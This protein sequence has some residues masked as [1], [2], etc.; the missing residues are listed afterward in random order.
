[1]FKYKTSYFSYSQCNATSHYCWHS[2][3]HYIF[4]QSNYYCLCTCCSKRFLNKSDIVSRPVI[5]NN[6]ICDC[7]NSNNHNEHIHVSVYSFIIPW[8]II[9]YTAVISYVVPYATFTGNRLIHCIIVSL[10]NE[11]TQPVCIY[12]CYLV[13]YYISLR[14]CDY[15]AWQTVSA[16][17]YIS[18]TIN[19]PAKCICRIIN[20][21]NIP[22]IHPLS[23]LYQ[24]IPVSSHFIVHLRH[25]S[26]FHCNASHFY[27][28]IWHCTNHNLISCRNSFYCVVGI[29]RKRFY[30]SDSYCCHCLFKIWVILNHII[31]TL[32][33]AIIKHNKPVT[34]MLFI[35]SCLPLLHISRI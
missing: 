7:Y 18:I 34:K 8:L 25:M 5:Y 23:K 26:L 35:N 13:C 3:N 28:F 31:F 16:L 4:K 24:C 6:L 11:I 20:S 2:K 10:T 1:M 30:T 12:I 19:Y 9:I 29:Y 21:Q 32:I 15:H 17:P 14:I 22:Y 33:G 27:E